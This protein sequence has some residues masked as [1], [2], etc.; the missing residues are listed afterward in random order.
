VIAG[1][2]PRESWVKPE[3]LDDPE[4]RRTVLAHEQTHFDIGE[5]HARRMR[6]VFAHLTGPCRKTDA[7]LSALARRLSHNEAMEQ[8]RYDSET[9]HGLNA[10]QQAAWSLQ[11]RERFAAS[12]P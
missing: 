3:I 1:F 10:A 12:L 11:T 8:A 5:L 7:D 9:N 2:R 6:E 4:T